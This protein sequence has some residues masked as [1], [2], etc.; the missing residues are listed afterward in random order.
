MVFGGCDHW[1]LTGKVCSL[2]LATPDIE[3]V[4]AIIGDAYQHSYLCDPRLCYRKNLGAAEIAELFCKADLALLP[5]STMSF[6]A[7]A[8]GTVLATGY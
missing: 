6:E 5:A 4:T 1:N 2:L 7:L 8:C 3:Q